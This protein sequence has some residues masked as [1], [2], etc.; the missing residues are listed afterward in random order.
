VLAGTSVVDVKALPPTSDSAKYHLL[1]VF[2][3]VRC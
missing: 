2:L 1:R 3:K